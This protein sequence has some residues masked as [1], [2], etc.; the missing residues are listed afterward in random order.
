MNV[1]LIERAIAREA[2]SAL[3]VERSRLYSFEAALDR[4]TTYSGALE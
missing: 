2:C 3:E 4:P 1:E